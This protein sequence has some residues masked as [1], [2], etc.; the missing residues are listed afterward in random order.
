MQ[1][2]TENSPFSLSPPCSVRSLKLYYKMLVGKKRKEK[3]KKKKKNSSWVE[4]KFCC[5]SALAARLQ[6]LVSLHTLRSSPS[7][8]LPYSLF[9]PLYLWLSVVLAWKSWQ[10]VSLSGDYIDN[11]TWCFSYSAT[12]CLC[13]LPYFPLPCHVAR[14]QLQCN[15]SD[16]AWLCAVW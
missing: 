10:L 3:E 1:R 6:F 13:P 4:Q 5:F 15:S 8:S 12:C 16:W 7:P 2:A 11:A 9:S 14:C